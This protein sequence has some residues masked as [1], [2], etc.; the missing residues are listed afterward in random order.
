MIKLRIAQ[1]ED[2]DGILSIYTPYVEE[3]NVT[4]DYDVE[5]AK[6]FCQKI[7]EMLVEFPWVIAEHEGKVIGYSYAKRHRDRVAY[8]WCAESSIYVHEDYQG[9][10][11]AKLLYEA[12]LEILNAQ[13]TI[14][15]YAGIAQP[16][17]GST[18]FHVKMGF[19]PVGVYK[20]V[21]FKNNQWHDVLWVHKILTKHPEK[22]E[23]YLPFSNNE[24]RRKAEEIIAVKQEILNKEQQL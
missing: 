16:N 18:M 5:E 23:K 4:F 12:L 7:D 24:V 6:V 1:S 22:P 9:K 17:E 15:V 14:N 13:N 2:A 3:T 8:N 11:L 10:G 19:T 21:G 20:K